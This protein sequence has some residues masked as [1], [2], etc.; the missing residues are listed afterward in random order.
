MHGGGGNAAAEA[1]S[2]QPSSSSQPPCADKA[3]AHSAFR[4]ATPPACFECSSSSASSLPSSS[5]TSSISFSPCVLHACCTEASA[6][7][8]LCSS[9]AVSSPAAATPLAASPPA[10]P[11]ASGAPAARP[12]GG[13]GLSLAL[14]ARNSSVDFRQHGYD[15]LTFVGRGQFGR[16][17]R[18]RRLSD[19][20]EWLAKQ[21]DL[22]ALDER[23][24]RLSLQEAEVMKQLEHPSVVRC[25]ESFVHNDTFLV[26][27]MEFCERGDLSALLVEQRRRAEFVEETRARKWLVQLTEGLQYIHSKRILHRDLKPSNILLDE[28][29]NVKIGDFGISRVMTTTLALAQTAVG[30]PQYMSPEMCENKPYTYKSDVWA[31]GCVLFELCS[32]KNA[33][34]GDSFLA[35]VWNIAFKPVPPLPPHYSPQL[36]QVIHAMLE[37]DPHKRPAPAAILASPLFIAF[38]ASDARHLEPR[39]DEPTRAAEEAPHSP[40]PSRTDP[41]APASLAAPSAPSARPPAPR[42]RAAS[43]CRSVGATLRGA[44]P[45]ELSPHKSARKRDRRE[46]RRRSSREASYEARQ[47]TAAD[48]D[49]QLRAAK[50][51]EGGRVLGDG[52]GD[53]GVERS[54]QEKVHATQELQETEEC[55]CE[56]ESRDTE[57]EWAQNRAE[58]S[59]APRS[60]VEAAEAA[61]ASPTGCERPEAGAEAEERRTCLRD[62]PAPGKTSPAPC[63]AGH[64]RGEDIE[65]PAAASHAEAER[66]NVSVSL[67]TLAAVST[68]HSSAT[69]NSPSSPDSGF[70][71]ETGAFSAHSPASSASPLFGPERK[72]LQMTKGDGSPLA[73][74]P[75]PPTADAKEKKPDAEAGLPQSEVNDETKSTELRLF[76][77]PPTQTREAKKIC[78]LCLGSSP[79]AAPAPRE[80]H[81]PRGDATSC[82][83]QAP[84][85][86]RLGVWDPCGNPRVISPLVAVLA[87]DGARTAPAKSCFRSAW[88]SADRHGDDGAASAS[89]DDE[90]RARPDRR[91][92][93]SMETRERARAR[94]G[95]LLAWRAAADE[96]D[97]PRGPRAA[98]EANAAVAEKQRGREEAARRRDHGDVGEHAKAPSGKRRAQHDAAAAPDRRGAAKRE[99]RRSPACGCDAEELVAEEACQRARSGAAEAAA[100]GRRSR[101]R[102]EEGVRGWRDSRPSARPAQLC[103]HGRRSI[104][105]ALETADYA[106]VVIGRIKRRLEEAPH[107]SPAE[108]LVLAFRLADE[109]R[110]CDEGG[111]PERTGSLGSAAASSP[112]EAAKANPEGETCRGPRHQGDQARSGSLRPPRREEARRGR[113]ES[114]LS[115]NL[116]L[117][118]RGE[119]AQ[120][121]PGLLRRGA[122]AEPTPRE[123]DAARSSGRDRDAFAEP[124]LGDDGAEA[125]SE[126]AGRSCACKQKRPA[127]AASGTAAQL[128]GGREART[129]AS[130]SFCSAKDDAEEGR[131]TT[132]EPRA[133]RGERRETES[134]SGCAEVSTTARDSGAE[135]GA[136]EEEGAPTKKRKMEAEDAEILDLPFDLDWMMR[137]GELLCAH[138]SVLECQILLSFLHTKKQNRRHSALLPRSASFQPAPHAPSLTPLLAGEPSAA[139]SL[140]LPTRSSGRLS[141]SGMSR[142]A[143]LAADAPR[144]AACRSSRCASGIVAHAS[145][146]PSAALTAHEFLDAVLLDVA[147]HAHYAQTL[148][149]GLGVLASAPE[150][151]DTQAVRASTPLAREE[152]GDGLADAEPFVRSASRTLNLPILSAFVRFDGNKLRCISRQLFRTVLHLYF[153]KLSSP[154]LD[155]L[156]Q[157]T[158]KAPSGFVRYERWLTTMATC[159]AHAADRRE[160]HAED[161]ALPGG[162]GGR[163]VTRSTPSTSSRESV[164]T[165]PLGASLLPRGAASPAVPGSAAQASACVSAAEPASGFRSSAPPFS[166]SLEAVAPSASSSNLPLPQSIPLSADCSSSAD[167]ASFAGG[168]RPSSFPQALLFYTS[169]LPAF[170]CAVAQPPTSSRTFSCPLPSTAPFSAPRLALRAARPSR[171]APAPSPACESR[172]VARRTRS[173]GAVAQAEAPSPRKEASVIAEASDSRLE[174]EAALCRTDA[175]RPPRRWGVR[176]QSCCTAGLEGDAGNSASWR[177][178]TPSPQGAL[179]PA[180][181]CLAVAATPAGLAAES[182]KTNNFDIGQSGGGGG[183]TA[184]NAATQTH[185]DRFKRN[186]AEGADALAKESS[187][188]G[189]GDRRGREIESE[190]ARAGVARTNAEGK[191]HLCAEETPPP[192]VPPGAPPPPPALSNDTRRGEN[193]TKSGGTAD[194]E[195]SGARGGTFPC[196]SRFRAPP[197]S[198]VPEKPREPASSDAGWL[199]VTSDAVAE[200][201]Q[202]DD[203]PKAAR[204]DSAPPSRKR[205]RALHSLRSQ[206]HSTSAS[207]LASSPFSSPFSLPS[208]PPLASSPSPSLALSA[209]L[210]SLS[211]SLAASPPATSAFSS[212]TPCSLFSSLAAPSFSFFAGTDATTFCGTPSPAGGNAGCKTPPSS[213][214]SARSP[215]CCPPSPFSAPGSAA[216]TASLGSTCSVSASLSAAPGG[217]GSL[218]TATAERDGNSRDLLVSEKGDAAAEPSRGRASD[219][220]RAAP[221]KVHADARAPFPSRQVPSPASSGGCKAARGGSRDVPRRAAPSSFSPPPSLLL[222][223]SLLGR[224]HPGAPCLPRPFG[225]PSSSSLQSLTCAPSL[226]SVAGVDAASQGSPLVAAPLRASESASSVGG[227]AFESAK[228][229][230]PSTRPAGDARLQATQ[231]GA[232]GAAQTQPAKSV[233]PEQQARPRASPVAAGEAPRKLCELCAPQGR[234]R[235]P[236]A[237][238]EA[239]GE[240]QCGEEERSARREDAGTA[241]GSEG[242]QEVREAFEPPPEQ[243]P[244][245]LSAERQ[246]KAALFTGETEG[247]KTDEEGAPAHPSLL[248][249]RDIDSGALLI[250]TECRPY[251]SKTAANRRRRHSAFN[252]LFSSEFGA[253]LRTPCPCENAAASSLPLAF[254]AISPCSACGFRD[255]HDRGN[256]PASGCGSFLLPSLSAV[257]SRGEMASLPPCAPR[258]RSTQLEEPRGR[259]EALDG[260]GRRGGRRRARNS[261]ERRAKMHRVRSSSVSSPPQSCASAS[262]PR[263]PAFSSSCAVLSSLASPRSPAAA[264]EAIGALQTL[265]HALQL[266]RTALCRRVTDPSAGSV[267]FLEARERETDAALDGA[268]ATLSLCCN[269][270]CREGP[271]QRGDCAWRTELRVP[272]RRPTAA[273]GKETRSGDE[274]RGREEETP[275]YSV[276]AGSLARQTS[277]WQ[278]ARSSR[279]DAARREGRNEDNAR[280]H[281]SDSEAAWLA[282]PPP[283]GAPD[284]AASCKEEDGDE[285]DIHGHEEGKRA[286]T[287]LG[288]LLTHAS[289]EA[290]CNGWLPGVHAEEYFDAVC[291]LREAAEELPERRRAIACL[292]SAFAAALPVRRARRLSAPSEWRARAAGSETEADTRDHSLASAPSAPPATTASSSPRASAAPFPAPSAS[293]RAQPARPPPS[294]SRACTPSETRRGSSKSPSVSAPL[295][296]SAAASPMESPSSM[297]LAALEPRCEGWVARTAN[298][299]HPLISALKSVSS[300][301]SAGASS[302]FAA[303]VNPS[304]APPTS[305]SRNLPRSQPRARAADLSPSASSCESSSA[306]PR[307]MCRRRRQSTQ[308]GEEGALQGRCEKGSAHA[309]RRRAEGDVLWPLAFAWGSRYACCAEFYS[310][311]IMKLFCWMTLRLPTFRLAPGDSSET[312][313]TTARAKRQRERRTREEK[314]RQ[315]TQRKVNEAA[316]LY[317]SLAFLK[318]QI[319]R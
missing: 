4:R 222:G 107:A 254:S 178:A 71:S 155:R 233:A 42:P 199:S 128:A 53:S 3:R 272:L 244:R 274:T 62:L 140:Q 317:R 80:L 203:A 310:N 17:F 132:R 90:A 183:A 176:T 268:L 313:E 63:E 130:S 195:D 124:L 187:A 61:S 207:S 299:T 23:D 231:E 28:G 208:A 138:L 164:Y 198:L 118:P 139:A 22:T 218:A 291:L 277:P 1:A 232:E 239:E 8:S 98:E 226:L 316:E 157:L 65:E 93:C 177:L 117:Q 147:S 69:A 134:S 307:G 159:L 281:S 220:G 263:S 165:P 202:A 243:G 86:G 142:R 209:A 19:S 158:E 201:S 298:V 269:S 74:A 282:A 123:N 224:T 301:P 191:R 305:F 241:F 213:I 81:T 175:P 97:T 236:P 29:E 96:E 101:K 169:S 235:R 311:L 262:R 99:E 136:R 32:L 181:A 297:S 214:A 84:R 166:L 206:S 56:R 64:P 79:L 200:A 148:Q 106:R 25:V 18:V 253:F 45:D 109:A 33:F 144:P 49:L 34:D 27:V 89:P 2:A 6:A 294:P 259:R 246:D 309:R 67:S 228:A 194:K 92:A 20:S 122:R 211:P 248:F 238:A 125:Q 82:G 296:S 55:H 160:V 219:A 51:G 247:E 39:R 9:A 186:V 104:S 85:E 47:H 108:L 303:G 40:T 230:R 75:R 14:P 196:A 300:A 38:Q 88:A 113:R 267:S 151:L 141:A 150:A 163:L 205:E 59:G 44:S 179:R 293:S 146:A 21:I 26:I 245:L 193:E 57:T 290:R 256:A 204:N 227:C 127:A 185:A 11:E 261:C 182:E 270:A 152:A 95:R 167:A 16:A 149:W 48:R 54:A 5:T 192:P 12:R 30:T 168:A 266:E 257:A 46:D 273:D 103:M 295:S 252:T 37:K 91:G 119:R 77:P 172:D 229:P 197:A 162:R 50:A 173:D 143:W 87:G 52:E 78:P 145:A 306:S 120:P 174:G 315:K 13:L 111:A 188:G 121:K 83:I 114:R 58:G 258:R 255:P 190:P 221:A 115:G 234:P 223:S 137:F 68:P 271:L 10:P 116:S 102:L 314:M 36:A 72:D 319:S 260:R 126:G 225:I 180:A 100:D 110:R 240:I 156:Y 73:S 131:A 285:G 265:V 31:L 286:E 129:V 112:E 312:G 184:E 275:A 304:G 24:R 15:V 302:A 287:S 35:L 283:E 242:S 278:C 76:L 318:E 276:T 251:A 41:A 210:A 66:P 133:S 292:A 250:P 170:A 279:L 161:G 264:A 288:S 217:A 216:S 237:V 212:S 154:Q 70:A 280:A 189:R 289:P 105:F 215:G 284:Y 7:S 43:V 153:P 60:L 171:R 135:S 308:R 94:R 249:D